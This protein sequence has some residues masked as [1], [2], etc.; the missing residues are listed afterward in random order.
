MTLL[1]LCVTG[2]WADDVTLFHWQINFNSAPTL[3]TAI[4]ATGG[5]VTPSVTSGSTNF[6][7]ENINGY[8]DGVPDDMKLTGSK[9]KAMKSGNDT[10]YYKIELSSG[11]FQA[12]D[13]IY[14]C[15]Y[16]GSQ[17]TIKISSSD[18]QTGDIS[19]TFSFPN[20][21]EAASVVS[22]TLPEGITYSGSLYIKRN[23]KT[24]GIAAIKIVRQENDTRTPVTLSFATSTGNA[25]ISDGATLPALTADPNVTAITNHI[26]YATSNSD[27]ASVNSSGTLTLN[28]IGTTTI[29][30]SFAGDDDYQ[31][32]S[33]TYKLTVTDRR[34]LG[35]TEVIN[36]SNNTLADRWTFGFDHASVAQTYANAIIDDGATVATLTMNGTNY[37][38]TKS[39]RKTQNGYSVSGKDQWVGYDITVDDNYVLN[40]THLDARILIADDTYK[41]YVEILDKNGEQVYKSTEQTTTKS[42]TANLSTDINV[43]NLNGTAKVKLWVTQGGT[44]KRFSIEKLIL[45]GTTTEDT[46][47]VRTITFAAGDGLGTAP[48]NTT[49]REGETYYFPTAPLLYKTDNTLTDWNDGSA[50]HEVGSSAT[51]SGNMDLTAVF[52]PNTVALGDAATTVEWT[53]K[54]ENGAPTLALE[55]SGTKTAV[56]AKRAIIGETPY[57]ALM[58][59]DAS[60]GK[61]NTTYNATY[62]QVNANTK[63]TIPAVDEMVVTLHCN[64]PTTAVTDASFDGND[65]DAFDATARTL[66]FTYSGPK[67][68]IDIVVNNGGLYPDGISI[69][70]PYVKTKYDAPTIVKGD[71]F[72]FEHKG[73]KVTITASEGTLNVSTDGTNYTEQTSPYE[74]YATATTTY[75]AKA[76]GADFNDSEVASLEVANSYDV[77][78][79][80]VAYVYQKDYSDSSVDYDFATD[81]LAIGL[82]A[83]YNVVPVEL[84]Q[85]DDPTAITDMDKA[86]L[87]ILT[88]AVKGSNTATDLSNKMKTYVGT[89]PMIGMKVFAYTYNTDASKNR[90]GWG[91]AANN[92]GKNAFMPKDNT[93][94]IFDGVVFEADGSIKLATATSGNIIQSVDFTT[95]ETPLSPNTIM[96]TVGTDDKKAVIH[97]TTKYL[98]VG[99]SCNVRESYTPNLITIVKN[100]AAILIANGDLTAKATFDKK[101][102][103]TITVSGWNSFSSVFPLDLNTITATNEVAAYY[104]SKAA[105]SFVTMT[106]TDATVP[107]GEGLMIKGTAGDE[108]LIDVVAS[109]TAIDGNLLVGLPNGG[110]VTKD[111]NNYVFAWPTAT[112]ADCGFYLIDDVEPT[113]PAGKAYLHTTTALT[114]RE[115]S[116]SFDGGTTGINAIDNGQLTIDTNAPMYNLAG[117][118]VNKS[119]KGVVIVNGKKMLNK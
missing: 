9:P 45:T 64:Q 66:T 62:A 111:D 49:A 96:G 41:W 106:E 102:T 23:G 80:Y 72:N 57:D 109:G 68:E 79:N 90:W 21:R 78:K 61:F 116:I 39:W 114:S 74:T 35:Y 44:S 17:G 115:L 48:A 55:S 70:Y 99:L 54:T 91:A 95:P 77:S 33:V 7:M 76:T 47:P 22:T 113:L 28:G 53:F 30:A 5:T 4:S 11:T 104:A 37:T 93:Y 50:D 46:R 20:D 18:A 42:N 51:I 73:Y 10:Q 85:A 117:Q 89:T 100:A 3:G 6:G 52:T 101:V 97:T 32:A 94:K 60:E 19:S 88:E 31:K 26:S 112:P 86:D 105:G 56:Y 16:Y 81:E 108:F 103:G 24:Y 27:V 25:D 107:A 58:T 2:A 82:A 59:I 118:R 63:F 119:Y 14:I 71:V 15:G 83:D 43:T 34:K 12:G 1:V 8:A 40:L 98:G 69:A 67:T 65:A 29:T 13:I 87:I 84:A 75:Y 110:K 92:S 36:S 38:N